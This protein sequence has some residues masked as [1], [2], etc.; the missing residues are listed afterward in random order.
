M[1]AAMCRWSATSITTATCCCRISGLARALAKFRINPGNV[2]FG[3]K[4]DRQFETMIEAALRLRPPGPDRR[5][6]GHPGPGPAD[7]PDGRERRLPEP[8]AADFVL[9]EALVRSALD[10]A[11]YAER[12]GL[13]PTGS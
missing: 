6:L 11:A 10:S 2:G 4:R 12:M 3:D 1:L 8:Q 7:P 5:Q 9:R 13:A